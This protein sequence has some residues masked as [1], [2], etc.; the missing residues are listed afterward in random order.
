MALEIT[1][2]SIGEV[3]QQDKLVVIDFW[4]EWCGPCR[5]VGPIIEELAADNPDILIGKVDVSEN[6]KSA[7]DYMITSI[8]CI[9]FI[10]G[11]QEVGRVKGAVPKKVLQAK[12]DEFK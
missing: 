12:I 7:S 3:L 9:V 1:D 11:G 5:M 10:K 8:P 6:A 4:A 2:Q